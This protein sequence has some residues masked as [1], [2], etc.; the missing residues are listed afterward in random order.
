MAAPG[1]DV[2]LP[3][4]ALAVALVLVALDDVQRDDLLLEV[5]PVNELPREKLTR[6]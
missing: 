6:S 4:T 1:V 3:A 2:I 5:E